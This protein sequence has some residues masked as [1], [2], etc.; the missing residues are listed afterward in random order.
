M[1]SISS[2]HPIS[3]QENSSQPQSDKA[4]SNFEKRVDQTAIPVLKSKAE[5]KAEKLQ[6]KNERL[7]SRLNKSGI[8]PEK[9]EKKTKSSKKKSA[10]PVS[11]ETTPLLSERESARKS[12]KVST[13]VLLRRLDNGGMP[14][15]K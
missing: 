2:H 12:Q 8:G 6:L 4:V 7:I 3:N 15:F 1:S 9:K 13:E 10:Q 5:L 11:S 14:Y